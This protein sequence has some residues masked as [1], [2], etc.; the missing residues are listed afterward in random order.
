MGR[1]VS[2]TLSSQDGGGSRGIPGQKVPRSSGALLGRSQPRAHSG[3]PGATCETL[4]EM[5]QGNGPGG[6]AGAAPASPGWRPCG[7]W[8]GRRGPR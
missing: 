5:V 1:Q 4:A 6:R 3:R 8:V 7:P 2:R